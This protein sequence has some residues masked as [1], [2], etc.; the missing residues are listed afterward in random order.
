M[1]F[2]QYYP[3]MVGVSENFIKKAFTSSNFYF[4]N[5]NFLSPSINSPEIEI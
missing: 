4:L 1:F 3:E 5:D 2:N